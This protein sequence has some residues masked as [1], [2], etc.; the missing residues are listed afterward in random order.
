MSLTTIFRPEMYSYEIFYVFYQY[1]RLFFFCVKTC[2]QAKNF[3]GLKKN[4][5]NITWEET[6]SG[7]I[8]VTLE[9]VSQAKSFFII[10]MA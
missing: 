1:F 4:N 8:F 9:H 7:Y 6:I 2:S 3:M 5:V 10:V